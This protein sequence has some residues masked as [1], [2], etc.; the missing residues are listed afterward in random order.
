M[1][2][3]LVVLLVFFMLA[4][5][6][7]ITPSV[8][9]TYFSDVSSSIL[10]WEKYDAIMYVADNGYM[11]GTDYNIF[12][13]ATIINRAQMVQ[14]LYQMAGEPSS[15]YNTPFTDV[16]TT[17]WYYHA[18]GWAYNNGITDGVT[19]TTFCPLIQLSRQQAITFLYR[20]AT[21]W[22]GL[23]FSPASLLWQYADGSSVSSYAVTPM[24]WAVTNCIV[25]PNTSNQL[26]PNSLTNR[27]DMALFLC[28]YDKNAVG[29]FDGKK[30][31]QFSNVSYSNQ[32]SIYMKNMLTSKIIASFP[33][34]QAMDIIDTIIADLDS[35]EGKCGGI[36]LVT[37]LDALGA[38]DFN[39]N[40]GN[41]TTMHDVPSYT[42][43]QTVLSAI[44]YYQL[45]QAA[46][47]YYRTITH[48]TADIAAF[49]TEV[50]NHG[51]LVVSYFW[52]VGEIHH[53]HCVIVDKI[54]N[55]ESGQYT[56]K[57]TDPNYSG[58]QTWQFTVNASTWVLNGQT[59]SS[60]EYYPF[61]AVQQ[62]QSFDIDGAYNNQPVY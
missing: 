61:D 58:M 53:G 54:T 59:I 32:M 46:F 3:F 50:I 43:N 48:T 22:C 40:V 33:Y 23:S 13:P 56:L 52:Y 38:L 9:A 15:N 34:S 18:V 39:I 7:R 29:F 11:V 47:Q 1:K 55:P 49:K 25:Q 62:I 28:R 42:T 19:D 27:G 17:A 31:L 51:P 5:I 36:S 6:V 20:Y 2:R 37:Y 44:N 12:E 26:L 35:S 60:F 30:K 16:P 24:N 8:T 14:L 57:C 4:C 21:I 45:G 10:G 41:Y